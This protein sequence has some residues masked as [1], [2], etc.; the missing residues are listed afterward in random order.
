MSQT[1]ACSEDQYLEQAQLQQ[2]ELMALEAILPSTDL[3]RPPASS[4]SPSLLRLSVPAVLPGPTYIVIRSH[5]YTVDKDDREDLESLAKGFEQV[6]I[7]KNARIRD[8]VPLQSRSQF[9]NRQRICHR[10]EETKLQGVCYLPPLRLLIRLPKAYPTFSAPEILHISGDHLSAACTDLPNLNQGIRKAKG[11]ASSA[12]AS[13]RAS[14]VQWLR[15]ALLQQWDNGE[16]L[17]IWHDFLKESMW[18]EPLS[19]YSCPLVGSQGTLTFDEFAVD[20]SKDKDKTFDSPLAVSLRSYDILSKRKEFEGE[21]FGCGICLE[22][23]RGGKC[24]K[25]SECGHVFCQECLSGY[26]S[27][28]IREGYI[29]QASSCPD[30]ECVK[31]R[32]AA[33]NKDD[34][35]QMRGME[36][37]KE[38]QEV[39]SIS[40]TELLQFVGQ[41]LVNRLEDLRDKALASTDPSAGYCPRPG[42]ERLVRGD[43]KDIGTMYESMRMCQCGYIYCLY[44]NKAWHG[45]SP[46]NLLSS[47]ALIERYQRAEEGSTI[48]KEM[49]LK[50]GKSN[51]ERMVKTHEEEVQNREY[52]ESNTQK[53]PCCAVRI[54]K[55]MGCN[56][57]TCRSCHTHLCYRCGTRLNPNEPY[58]HFNTPGAPCFQKLFDVVIG[59]GG[60][61]GWG[62][63][64]GEHPGVDAD[65]L[66]QWEAE[67]L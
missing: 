37:K 14:L 51:L 48:R 49:E 20:E 43:P 2:D 41:E 53:C 10:I 9:N 12:A 18:Q 27:S 45:K 17:F 52:I 55:S 24:W 59:G 5:I 42:C 25:V 29:R 31:A 30:P 50:Y 61:D 54:E 58:R 21:R 44:C 33:E 57:M 35:E 60:D 4:S 32:V 11:L 63:W 16:V 40:G 19:K 26:L 3:K 39:G 46:C 7:G 28:M 23:K 22:E 13:L 64:G 47:T 15:K 56:H 62:G 8:E 65:E 36:K 6:S 66:A 34:A 67:E 1:Q 38:D